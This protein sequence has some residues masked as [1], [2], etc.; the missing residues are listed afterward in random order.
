M[1]MRWMRVVGLLLLCVYAAAVAHQI[2]PHHLGHGNG[3]SCSLCLLLTSIV[4]L[5]LAV[6]LR[7]EHVLKAFLLPSHARVLSRQIQQPFSIRGPPFVSF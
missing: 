7:L 4:L 1:R 6:T 2:L 5:A 3:G